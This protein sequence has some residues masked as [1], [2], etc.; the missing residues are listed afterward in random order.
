MQFSDPLTVV[1]GNNLRM[2]GDFITTF[3]DTITLIS[4]GA[5]W[6]ETSRSNN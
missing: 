5:N 2:A 3:T 1:E 4:D 6:I